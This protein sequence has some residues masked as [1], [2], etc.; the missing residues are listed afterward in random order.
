LLPD[1]TL[2]R[3]EACDVDDTTAQITLRVQSTQTRAPCP[4]CAT[5]ARRIHSDYGRTLADLPWAQYRVS[6][7]LRVRKWFCRNRACPRRIFTERLPTV[8]A[9]W[10]RRTLRLAQRLIALGMALGGKAGVRLG[11]QW[12]VGVSRHTLLRGLRRQ[13]ALA[14]PTP[15]V[16]GVDD[17]ALRKRHTYGTILVDLERRQPVELLPDR[18][19]E[20]VAQWLRAHPGVEVIARDRSSTYA[21]GARQGASEAIQVA[22]RFHVLQNLRATLDEVFTTHH[23][24][25]DTVNAAA[26]RQPVPLPDG[27][28]AVP[29]P[30]PPPPARAEQQAAQRAAQRQAL[31]EQVW[32]LHRQ[33]WPVVAIATQVG[34]GR[35]TIER[36]LRLP[37]WPGRQHR[38]HYGRGLLH[39]YTDYLLERWNAG[40]HTAIQLFRELQPRG[41]T[42][43][44]RRVAAYVSR[45][46]QAQGVPPRRQ[47]RR[48]PLPVVVEPACQP[49]TPRRA[50]WL[51]L[52]REAQRTEAEAHQLKQLHAQSA[53]VAE[54]IDLAQD[55]ALLVRQRQPTQLDPW[56]QRA[57]TSTLE[58][59]QR[60]AQGLRDD[61][62]A[63]KAGVTLPWSTS[64]V[65]G[66]INRLKMVKRQMFGRARLDLLSHRFVLAPRE[67]PAQAPAQC[68]PA[69]ADAAAEAA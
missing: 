34:R 24:A 53:E 33:G 25:L 41:Y 64:P 17:F 39:P 19:A 66:H 29:V 59:L 60:F 45:V 54:A 49:L 57:T 46:R 2:L 47:G 35:R 11:H 56:L 37:T 27:T 7:Q 52:R 30:P 55:F 12:D 18:T 26:R 67:R 51:V 23:H 3:L 43:S 62:E 16:L 65:E 63:V 38:S 69:Q 50:T 21:E 15:R 31:Y 22:D 42:G 6:L 61:Y 58:A 44:Y 40:C 10:A 20:T 28:L 9:P 36:Y 68:E 48:Q 32:A 8:A 4:L 13:P 1:A 5:P 14:L